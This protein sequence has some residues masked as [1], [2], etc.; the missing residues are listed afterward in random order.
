M[1][2]LCFVYVYAEADGV[3]VLPQCCAPLS[4][5]SI[6]APGAVRA[7]GFQSILASTG[8]C[9]GYQVFLLHLKLDCLNKSISGNIVWSFSTSIDWQLIWHC[10]LMSFLFL[11]YMSRI[12]KP[13]FNL[14]TSVAT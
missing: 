7:F 5:D 12:T 4:P 8:F 6:L 13:K 1:F 11:G 14:L 2:A 9:L 3:V 10:A